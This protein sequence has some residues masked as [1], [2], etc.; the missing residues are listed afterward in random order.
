[1]LSSILLFFSIN[2]PDCLPSYHFL[3]AK[4]TI[5]RS[6]TSSQ[7]QRIQTHFHITATVKACGCDNIAS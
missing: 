5:N 7:L 3:K 1:M 4:F 6:C 2:A